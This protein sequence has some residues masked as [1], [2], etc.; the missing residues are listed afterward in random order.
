MKFL[1]CLSI[2]MVIVFFGSFIYGA[3]YNVAR[4]GNISDMCKSHGYDSVGD[5]GNR[6][7]YCSDRK[8]GYLINPMV[9]K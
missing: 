6:G 2:L 7:I 9:L 4:D 8:T 5:T 1:F 3:A